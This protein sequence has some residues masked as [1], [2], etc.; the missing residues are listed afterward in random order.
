M[1]LLRDLVQRGCVSTDQMSF[2]PDLVRV[3]HIVI[4][5]TFQS[6]WHLNGRALGILVAR[7]KRSYEAVKFYAC[8]YCGEF[9]LGAV[10]GVTGVPVGHQDHQSEFS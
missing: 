3:Q 6:F 1:F 8:D 10:Q 7:I 9:S 5:P 4:R 2:Y